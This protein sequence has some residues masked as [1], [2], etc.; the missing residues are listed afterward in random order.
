[1]GMNSYVVREIATNY[2]LTPKYLG[3]TI[4]LKSLFSIGTFILTLIILI[5]MKSNELTVTI[6]LLFTIEMIFK[7]LTGLLNGAFQAHENGKY[8][9]IGNVLSN[10]LLLIFILISICTDL[11]IYGIAISYVLSN[12]LAFVYEY[13]MLQRKIAKP[14]FEID[15][16]FCK[17]ITLLAL[18]FAIS[19]IFY[20]I[21][22]SVD[23]VMLDY[24]VGDYATGIYSAAYKLISVLTVFYSVYTAVLYP[25]MSKF[26]K[27]DEQ[28]LV[29]V[30]EKSVKYLSLLIIPLAVA[31]TIYSGDII[32]LIFGVEYSEASVVLSILIWTVCLIFING[33]CGTLLNASHKEVAGTKICI[34]A[35]VFNILLNLYMI[36]HFS[37][38]GAAVSTVL[39]DILI[40]ILSAYI[41]FRLGYKINKNLY[42]NI[43]KIIISSLILGSSLIVLDLNMWIA[44]PVGIIIYFVIVYLL[45]IFDYNDKYVIKEILGKN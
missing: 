20:N 41:I 5:L 37:Y 6:T 31:T 24:L 7:T 16:E 18:P 36:P 29:I 4:P 30:F 33:A 12:M 28:L 22:Y 42:F 19:G 13:Y 27:N 11:G 44:I 32:Q 8:Q 3:N 40:F 35:A 25:V 45:K 10:L 17:T 23:T 26:F 2:D 15:F 9:G 14:K 21:Y 43:F 38:N 1:M 34:I 39:S